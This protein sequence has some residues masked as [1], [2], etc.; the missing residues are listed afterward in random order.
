MNAIMD[1]AADNDLVVIE[2]ACQ[3][4]GA[5]FEGKKVG[6]FSTRYF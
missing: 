4:H 6:S 2:D 5:T 1:I 3:A